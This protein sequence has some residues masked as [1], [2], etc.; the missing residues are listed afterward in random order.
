ML[1]HLPLSGHDLQGLGDILAQLGQPGAAAAGACRRTRDDDA[2]ARQVLGKR[3][4]GRTRA[5][6][7]RDGGGLGRGGLGGQLVL[8]G[9]RLQLLE[10]QLHLVQQAGGALGARAE[11]VAVELLDLQLEMGDQRAIAGLLRQGSGGLR[12]DPG[13][14]GACGQE[15]CLERVDVI[16]QGS[17]LG[18]HAED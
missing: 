7:A 1:D 3:A 17:K 8:G 10:L 15:R 2:L 12:G 14:I 4:P 6:E 11:A 18:L 9:G 13:D 5:G 16:R